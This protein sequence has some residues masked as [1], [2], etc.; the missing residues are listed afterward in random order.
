MARCVHNRALFTIQQPDPIPFHPLPLS[1]G[2][3][4]YLRVSCTIIGSGALQ[5]GQACYNRVGHAI[6]G[7]VMLLL[8]WLCYYWVGCAIIRLVVLLSGWSHYYQVGHTII[9][10][11]WCAFPPCFIPLLCML[12]PTTP[13]KG[14]AFTYMLPYLTSVIATLGACP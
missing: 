7:L 12:F 10:S 3:L 8:G 1:R 13:C 5:S 11:S 6:I 9:G 2:L 14:L 4:H